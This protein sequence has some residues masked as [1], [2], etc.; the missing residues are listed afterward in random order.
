MVGPPLLKAVQMVLDYGLEDKMQGIY[1]KGTIDIKL[2]NVLQ[3][4]KQGIE[5]GDTS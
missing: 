5:E 1:V 4:I 2:S 3:G